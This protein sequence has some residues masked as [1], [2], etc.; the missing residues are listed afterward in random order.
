[1]FDVYRGPGLAEGMKS[2]AIR[3]TLRATDR[4]LTDAE[5]APVRR[6]IVERVE[7]ATGGDLRGEA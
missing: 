3:L 6:S 2:I 4:T 7:A 1:V 5:V